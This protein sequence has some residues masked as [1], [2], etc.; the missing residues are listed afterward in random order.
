MVVASLAPLGS[1]WHGERGTRVRISLGRRKKIN[2]CA[3]RME[4]LM[5]KVTEALESCK[6][7]SE[8][9]I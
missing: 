5:Q 3:P 2:L 8:E 7:D 6:E 9:M 4:P 1:G